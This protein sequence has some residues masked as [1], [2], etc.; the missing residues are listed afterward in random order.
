MLNVILHN[1]G[2]CN[3]VSLSINQ[4]F[5][6]TFLYSDA[7]TK[8][9]SLSRKVKVLITQSC[10]TVISG[11]VACQAHLSMEFSS[12]EYW[13]GLSFPSPGD[14]PNPGIKPRSLA[15]WADSLPSEPPEKPFIIRT[16]H[17]KAYKQS[18]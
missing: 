7:V 6:H 1:S 2:Y 9:V 18:H 12:R 5:N 11:S 16:I 17:R 13:S 15:S 14:L 3:Q 4:M 8:S 10:L